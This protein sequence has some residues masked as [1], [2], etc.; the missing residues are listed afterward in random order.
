MK[1]HKQ[2]FVNNKWEAVSTDLNQDKCQLVLVFGSPE[3][4]VDPAIFD[5]LKSSYPNA[6]IVL[7]STAGEIIKDSVFDDSVVATAIEFEKTPVKSVSINISDFNSSYEAGIFLKKQLDAADL[8]GVFIISDGTLVDGA[9][10]VKGLAEN[11][12]KNIPITGGLAGDAVRFQK[13]FTGLNEIPA[14]GNIVA[15][16]FYGSHIFIGHGSLGG[17][18]EFGFERVITRSQ[19]NI[20]HELDN[21]NALDLYKK[22]LGAFADELPGSALLFPLSMAVAGS[23][24]RIIRTI[25]A[26]NEEDKS[27]VFAGSVPQ[28]SKVK[29]MRGNLDRLVEASATAAQDSLTRLGDLKPDLTLMISCVGRKIILNKMVNEEVEV[30]REVLGSDSCISGFYSY[31]GISPLDNTTPCELHNQ[32]MTI[33]TFAEN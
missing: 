3:L 19:K 20:L 9:D 22:Y 10:L 25:L 33:T 12:T 21:G 8:A 28:D 32:T 16:G 23:D 27:M 2:H 1:I 7:S 6:A 13:T 24:K 11:N 26:V 14:Q 31:G 4:V 15:V 5:H 30:A 29:L 18:E 17:W